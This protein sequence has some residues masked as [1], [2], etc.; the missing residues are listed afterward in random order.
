MSDAVL[1]KGNLTKINFNSLR[2]TNQAFQL[3]LKGSAFLKSVKVEEVVL[4]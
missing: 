4:V 2:C 1:P 3:M